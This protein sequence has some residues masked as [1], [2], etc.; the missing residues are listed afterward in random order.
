MS[1]VLARKRE[2]VEGLIAMHLDLY[3]ASGAELIM[4][5]GRFIAPNTIE[6]SLN[7]GGKRRAARRI[8]VFLNLGTHATIPDIPGLAGGAADERRSA[9]ARSAAGAPDRA[10][11]RLCRAGT[12]AGVSALRQPGDDRRSGAAAGRREDADVAGAVSEI[13]AMRDIEVLLAQSARCR[14]PVG[15]GVVSRLQRADGGADGRRE[16]YSGRGRAHAEHGRH[17]A[18]VAGVRLDARGYIA[19]NER[20]ETSAAGGLGDR[21]MRG[22]PAVHPCVVRRFPRYPRQSAGGTRSTRDRL[23]PYCMFTDPPLAR[24]GSERSGSRSDRARGA[25]R[26][27]ADRCGVAVAHDFGDARVHEGAGRRRRRPHP[28]LRHDRRRG[29]RGVAVVQTA[30]LAGMPFTALRDA[31]LTHPTMAEGL[32]PLFSRAPN[33]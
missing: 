14:G 19:V 1:K 2:M 22:Q 20:L 31:I 23:V 7:D 11:R 30:M 4:G 15:R 25:R 9:G 18:R 21:R 24:V 13:C 5:S 26:Q 27:A 32:G 33:R 28:R 6:V 8:E 3:K 17:R 10:G 12:G 29:G 16:R